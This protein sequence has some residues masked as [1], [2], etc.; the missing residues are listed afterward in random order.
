MIK[1]LLSRYQNL[2]IVLGLILTL[3]L[4]AC[5][6][7]TPIPATAVPTK[8]NTIPATIA[9]AT[10]TVAVTATPVVIATAAPTVTRIPTTTTVPATTAVPV[11]TPAAVQNA[12]G[13]VLAFS[14]EN[15]YN[16]VK[17]LASDIG[18]RLAGSENQKKAADY[19]SKQ[20]ETF[21]LKATFQDST[22]LLRVE[23]GSNLTVS[24]ENTSAKVTLIYVGSGEPGQTNAELAYIAGDL[25]ESDNFSGKVMLIQA[26]NRSLSQIIQK[27]AA[28]PESS[29]PVALLIIPTQAEPLLPPNLRVAALPIAYIEQAAGQK[30]IER[31]GNETLK[32]TLNLKFDKSNAVIRNVIGTRPAAG[33]NPNAPVI[34]IGGHYDSVPAGPGANDNGSGTGITIELA[35]VLTK[36]YP[37]VEFRFIAFD[38]EELGLI[39]SQYYVKQLSV[40]EKSRIQAMFNLDMVTTGQ[41]LTVAGSKNLADI[42]RTVV[43]NQGYRD[44][45]IRTSTASDGSS[46]HASFAQANIPVL[47]FNRQSDPNY[48]RSSDTIDKFTSK[49]LE[50]VA[51]IMQ[52]TLKQL[53]SRG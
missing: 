46:D 24:G 39:G 47:F 33:N 28:M 51:Q 11:T 20:F 32:V 40:A 29:R 12:P 4:A 48:H 41:T 2:L 49:P 17:V 7:P 42:A 16:H 8:A 6:E 25:A 23:K 1:R 38:G 21:G 45:E 35:R 26:S 14:A 50:Q 37:D 19:I 52:A 9:P 15:A 43:V 44:T 13:E 27:I 3:G 30:L 31:A 34:I 22:F 10:N 5:G 18:I 36:A 53:L